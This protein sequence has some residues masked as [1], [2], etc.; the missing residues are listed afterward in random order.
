M[1]LELNEK[2]F[3][4]EVL[5]FAGPVLVDFWAPW[6]GPC[7]AIGPIIDAISRDYAGKVKVAKI[8]VD[9]SQALAGKYGVMSIPTLA[10]FV[11]GK[12][13]HTH[14][15][16]TSQADLAKLIEKHLLGGK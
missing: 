6:C 14:V 3:D 11:A 7:K 8:N 2:N 9:D 15:G 13:V 12:V 1:A 5:N 10:F 16:A 4:Q